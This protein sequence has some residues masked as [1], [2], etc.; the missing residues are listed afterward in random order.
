[1]SQAHRQSRGSH[2]IRV[3]ARRWRAERRRA[4]AGPANRFEVAFCLAQLALRPSGWPER[5]VVYAP[6]FLSQDLGA[7]WCKV[8][9]PVPQAV[10][11]HPSGLRRRLTPELG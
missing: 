4:H 11:C 1:M 8:A 3:A 5:C 7:G 6:L 10:Q 2:P 9:A